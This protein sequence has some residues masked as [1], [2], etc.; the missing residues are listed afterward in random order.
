MRL[1]EALRLRVKDINFARNEI[2]VRGGKGSRPGHDASGAAEGA[3][4]A[5]FGRG[6][7][8][9]QDG[10]GAARSSGRIHHDGVHARPQPGRQGREESRRYAVILRLDRPA[11]F[12]T[13]EGDLRDRQGDM[14]SET[15]KTVLSKYR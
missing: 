12:I 7:R 11:Y 5:S 6:A 10:A 13:H 14:D 15:F 1:L 4:A 2:T 8:A 9:A 3:L